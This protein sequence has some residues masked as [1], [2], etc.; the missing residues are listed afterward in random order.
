MVAAHWQ[1]ESAAQPDRAVRGSDIDL[2][3]VTG[4]EKPRRPPKHGNEQAADQPWP[5]AS[6]G[7]GL[8]CR[9]TERNGVDAFVAVV[10]AAT[11]DVD[12]RRCGRNGQVAAAAILDVE[13]APAIARTDAQSATRH[14][15]DVA[16]MQPRRTRHGR[17][18]A[19]RGL[20]SC[21]RLQE[22]LAVVQRKPGERARTRARQH[23]RMPGAA[24]T[25]GKIRSRQRA[26]A[27]GIA[28]DQF[29]GTQIGSSQRT[30]SVDGGAPGS[31][32]SSLRTS[33]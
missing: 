28:Q 19:E 20:A 26:L 7:R 13:D 31:R 16:F 2:H 14:V 32:F 1:D 25:D 3:G 22:Q 15:D 21:R 5:D 18:I 24:D 9:P 17:A 11:D 27:E 33:R 23:D 8:R 10:T 29:G 6:I 4:R 30:T 12:E